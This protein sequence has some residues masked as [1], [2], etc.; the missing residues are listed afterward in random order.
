MNRKIGISFRNGVLLYKQLIR[1]I[2]DYA[3]PAWRSAA[4]FHVRRL[5]VL[6]SKCLLPATGA[7]TRIWVFRFCRHQNPGCEFWLKVSWR[8]EPPITA[9]RQMLTLTEGL[10]LAWRQGWQGPAGQ[11]RPSSAMAKSTKR[12][13]LG[14]DQTSAF[15]LPWLR[16]SVIFLSCKANSRVYDAKSGHDP[17]SPPPGAAA[18]PKRLK[19]V[20]NLQFAT[21]P[22]WA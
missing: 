13:A 19:K 1:P 8:G 12:I 2:M 3:C 5:Q 14:A 22:V 17:H 7:Q 15:R 9:T 21:E 20:A 10:P 6:Q 18:S 4:H 16:F 11:S